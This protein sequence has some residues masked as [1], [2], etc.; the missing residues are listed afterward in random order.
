M[1]ALLEQ[2]CKRLGRQAAP[3]PASDGVDSLPASL[4]FLRFALTY[5]AHL[6]MA[7]SLT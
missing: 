3:E 4:T 1:E 6:Q 2:I 7:F 5:N